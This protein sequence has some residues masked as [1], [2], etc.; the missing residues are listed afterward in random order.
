MDEVIGDTVASDP[1]SVS[2]AQ[3]CSQGFLDELH[4]SQSR[5]L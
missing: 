4:D 5:Y 3:L 1:L 2:E